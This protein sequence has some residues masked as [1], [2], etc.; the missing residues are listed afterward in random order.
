MRSA[1]LIK[2]YDAVPSRRPV[3]WVPLKVQSPPPARRG[4]CCQARRPPLPAKD[5]I[6]TSLYLLP[7]RKGAGLS[8]Y[9]YRYQGR[10]KLL[11]FGGYPA[12]WNVTDLSGWPGSSP[13]PS[14]L[15]LRPS[16]VETPDALRQPGEHCQGD[17]AIDYLAERVPI[18]NDPQRDESGRNTAE[19]QHRTR[20]KTM[21]TTAA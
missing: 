20:E 11:S 18:R 19:P 4:T 21:A 16:G 10:E 13:H 15:Q 5:A 7:R 8:Q 14:E 3:C 9:R 1:G 17:R 2:T 12:R 6:G